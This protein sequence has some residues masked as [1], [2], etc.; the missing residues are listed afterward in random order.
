ML[1]AAVRDLH[2]TFPGQFITDVRTSCPALWEHNPHITP[3]RDDDPET[4]VIECNYP[5]IHKSNQYPYHFIHGFIEDLGERL[6]LRIQPGLF[7]GDIHLTDQE[8]HWMSQVQEITKEQIPFWII[9]AGGK[10]DFTIKWW[11][12]VR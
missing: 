7:K 1:T 2:H 12:S 9:V 4:E 10:S 5:L 8:K 11:D 6:G 3:L